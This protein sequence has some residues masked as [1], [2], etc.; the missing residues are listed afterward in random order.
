M[1]RGKREEKREEGRSCSAKARPRIE[2]SQTEPRLVRLAGVV[3]LVCFLA[4]VRFAATVAM[5]RTISP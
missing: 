3:Y 5:K 4:H 1:R 2:S